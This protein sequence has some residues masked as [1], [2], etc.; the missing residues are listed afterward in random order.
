[1]RIKK[2]ENEGIIKMLKNIRKTL[3]EKR[4]AYLTTDNK[5]LSIAIALLI[6]SLFALATPLIAMFMFLTYIAAMILVLVQR[7]ERKQQEKTRKAGF[8]NN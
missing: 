4:L 5:P 2:H 6:F 7:S 1:M 3:R 8:R